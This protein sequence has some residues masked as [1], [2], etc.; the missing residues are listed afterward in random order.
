MCL[1]IKSFVSKFTEQKTK[2]NIVFIYFNTFDYQ[3]ELKKRCKLYVVL[4][5]IK[6]YYI[7][8]WNKNN[9]LLK[10]LPFEEP[11]ADNIVGSW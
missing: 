5:G 10:C 4:V 7:G 2:I 9:V 3:Y 1:F 8:V 6:Y 11:K